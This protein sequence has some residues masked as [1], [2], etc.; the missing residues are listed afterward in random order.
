MSPSRFLMRNLQ[1]LVITGR[2]RVIFCGS[3]ATSFT[4]LTSDPAGWSSLMQTLIAPTPRE[5]LLE[6]PQVPADCPIS[7]IDT[8]FETGYLWSADE[9]ESLTARQAQAMAIAPALHLAAT[10]AKCRHLLVGCCG[11]VVAGLMAQTL[12]SLQFSGFQNQLDV[13]LTQ[14]ASRFLTRE[15][16]EAYG[17]RCWQDGFE[18]QDGIRVPHVS[19]AKSADMICILPATADSLDRIARSACSDLLSLTIT[20][21]AAPVLL[22]PVMNTAMWNNA[23][24]QRNVARIRADGHFVLE[25]SLIIGAADFERDAP[26][27]YGGH[28]C[29]W[30]GPAGLM[31]AMD[32]VKRQQRS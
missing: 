7:L 4:H 30:P 28:G 9:A 22:A 29:L 6:G 26:P 24:V 14:S 17:I 13:I 8:L 12:L 16:L 21:S 18:Q 31:A 19:L 27:M 2:D 32:A 5:A 23:G 10:K 1:R 25:P 20:S 3:E 15:L 11:S